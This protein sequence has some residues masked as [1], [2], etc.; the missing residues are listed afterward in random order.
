M[1]YL[2]NEILENIFLRLPQTYKLSTASVCKALYQLIQPY[3]YSSI[4]I[5]SQQQLTRFI[6][7]AKEKT[8]NNKLIGHY[9]QHLN[10]TFYMDNMEKELL[11][12]ITKA[13]PNIQSIDGFYILDV[14]P[15]DDYLPELKQLTHYKE[16][17]MICNKS[18]AT[19]LYNN[20]G[21]VK[22]LDIDRNIELEMI[23]DKKQHSLPLPPIHLKHFGP[24]IQIP[25]YVDD[26][27]YE[28][29]KTILILPILKNLTY[30]NISFPDLKVDNIDINHSIVY[31]MEEHYKFL[32][33]DEYAFENISQSCPK[34][35]TLSLSNIAMTI[36]EDYDHKLKYNSND[37]TII[38]QQ[39]HHLKSLDIEGKIIYPQCFTYL[40]KKYPRINTLRLELIT[41][42]LPIELSEVYQSAIHDAM[43]KFQFLKTLDIDIDYPQDRMSTQLEN[44]M[45]N[46][47]FWP[48]NEFLQ[49]LLQYPTQLTSLRYN[50]YS[51]EDYNKQFMMTIDTSDEIITNN[52]TNMIKK[53]VKQHHSFNH[54]TYLSLSPTLSYNALYYYLIQNENSIIL[55]SSIATF[56][57]HGHSDELN[58]PIYITDWLDTFPGLTKLEIYRCRIIN[59]KDDLYDKDY[60]DRGI[61]NSTNNEI[62]L[63]EWNNDNISVHKSHN[64]IEQR[65]RQQLDFFNSDYN[66]NNNPTYK[67][68]NLTLYRSE[69]AMK[70]GFNDFL[71]KTSYVKMLT[72]CDVDLLYPEPDAST[73]PPPS[74][75][76][77]PVKKIYFDLSQNHLE[78][79]NINNFNIYS[80]INDIYYGYY[81]VNELI[82]HETTSD[83][84]RTIKN[85]ADIYSSRPLTT[86]DGDQI[87]TGVI[88]KVYEEDCTILLKCKYTN[89][90]NFKW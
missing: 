72:L 84:K 19:I 28:M 9:V 49:C 46:K 76:I 35:E 47:T 17:Y 20:R 30:L 5:H 87:Y 2:P 42:P 53:V 86:S 54:L 23:D 50:H 73:L 64:L 7:L 61:G 48:N 69:I 36:S 83:E 41:I 11:L 32:Y 24:T 43:M 70:I 56:F 71:K 15:E 81:Y 39:P 16:W 74:S 33:I 58:Q 4:D 8:I 85:N 79:L 65:K 34:L 38:F 1:E 80:R 18:W 13:F 66:N 10:F 88:T 89:K 52:Y 78:Q 22:H 26:G 14:A 63:R 60:Y 55:S 40:S 25:P 29:I 62:Y 6:K 75:K 3:F 68:N 51:L 37:T 77:N 27:E 21:K 90:I 82:I 12:E 67:L 45:V 57:M 31:D 59:D 44:G